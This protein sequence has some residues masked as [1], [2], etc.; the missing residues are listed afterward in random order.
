MLTLLPTVTIEIGV[1]VGS[2]PDSYGDII[3]NWIYEV[4]PG[5][6]VAP[7]STIERSAPFDRLDETKIEVYIPTA[8]TKSLKNARIKFWGNTYKVVGNPIPY[9]WSPLPWN[10]NVICEEVLFNE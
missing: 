8:F 4:L 10:R 6:I 3:F 5:V 7:Y 9:M 1:E 2:E